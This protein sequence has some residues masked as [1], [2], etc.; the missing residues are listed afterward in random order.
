MGARGWLMTPRCLALVSRSCQDRP[1]PAARRRAA[2]SVCPQSPLLSMSSSPSSSASVVSSLV[3]TFLRA[4]NPARLS[5]WMLLE[6]AAALGFILYGLQRLRKIKLDDVIKVRKMPGRRRGPSS[7]TR[8]E[9]AVR[10]GEGL[11][12]AGG[13]H[14]RDHPGSKLF[15][16]ALVG[17]GG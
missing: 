14:A 15:R 13:A 7:A 10:Q 4:N 8:P 1:R 2:P 16:G 9:G 5:G 11:P 12:L 3:Q 6:K 17:L